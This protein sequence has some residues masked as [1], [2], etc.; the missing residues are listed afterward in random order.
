MQLRYEEPLTR[1]CQIGSLRCPF[2]G[3]FFVLPLVVPTVLILWLSAT[4]RP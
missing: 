3:R 1:G 2:R 4:D